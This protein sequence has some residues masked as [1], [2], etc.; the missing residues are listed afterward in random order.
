MSIKILSVISFFLRVGVCLVAHALMIQNISA[1][2]LVPN[3]S[4]ELLTDNPE[5]G[6][7]GVNSSVDWF[8]LG[9]TTEFF[10]RSYAAVASV[11][12]N[13]RGFQEPY[14]GDGYAGMIV[15]PLDAR[16][17]L[18]VQLTAPLE[19]GE[20]YTLSFQVCLSERSK[21]RTDDFGAML[22]HNRP[23]QDSLS[24]YYYTV[25]NLEGRVLSDTSGWMEIRG[26]YLA[27]GGEEYLLIGNLYDQARTT[28][29]ETGVENASSWAY[30][31][32]DQVVLERCGETG[33][34][35]TQLPPKDTVICDSGSAML[36][37]LPDADGYYWVGEGIEPVLQTRRPGRYTL[38]HYYGCDIL[39]QSFTV[40]TDGC[41]CDITFPSPSRLP[42]ELRPLPSRNVENYT[43]EL[44]NAAGQ[45]VWSGDQE[46]LSQ[47]K[48]SL[49]AGIY[50]WRA[51]LDCFRELDQ[52]PFQ[53]TTS[54]R[55]LFVD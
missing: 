40:E 6:P 45:K 38:N 21:F 34:S 20:V 14:M 15:Y 11:P 28:F 12:A 37:G 50:F 51:R 29:E 53:R 4:F 2:N 8:V 9:F 3:P 24:R 22:L 27:E 7:T 46:S 30:Y 39:Q 26:Q 44:F 32:V 18:A 31:Y 1:Q 42:A 25:K 17:F 49:A 5:Y 10:H 48:L 13:Q 41:F 43:L 47:T 52:Q 33:S 36:E 55:I 23:E 35:V 54:G 19:P 16:E